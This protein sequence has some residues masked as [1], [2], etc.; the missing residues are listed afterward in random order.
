[1]IQVEQKC[2]FGLNNDRSCC[3]LTS[4]LCVTLFQSVRERFVGFPWSEAHGDHVDDLGVG[5]FPTVREVME[6]GC[7]LP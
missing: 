6:L 4:S 1:M 5:S 2:S 7:V 3:D